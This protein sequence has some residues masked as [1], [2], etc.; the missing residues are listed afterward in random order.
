MPQSTD[1]LMQNE[2]FGYAGLDRVGKICGWNRAAELIT[3]YRPEEVIGK[4][5]CLFFTPEDTALKV[6][7]REMERALEMGKAEDQRW[8]LKKDGTRF[9]AAGAMTVSRDADGKV[10]GLSKIFR[11]DT[12]RKQTEDHIKS[13]NA[14]LNRFSYTVAHD[15]QQPLRTLTTYVELAFRKNLHSFD[16]ES[17]EY[18]RIAVDASKRMRALISDLLA[19]SKSDHK[20]ELRER[21]DCNAIFEDAQANLQEH[22]NTARA[23]IA[24]ST[25]PTLPGVG[26]QLVQVF[27]NLLENAIKYRRPDVKLEIRVD[28]IHLPPFWRFSVSD[29]GVGIADVDKER[30]F[31][32]FERA[33]SGKTESGS[34]LGLSICK[35]IVEQHGGTIWVESNA[36]HGSTFFFT[37]R[38]N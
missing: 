29:N 14:D 26:S 18:V 6:P 2:V 15:L 11:D 19:L 1:E 7:D 32:A 12:V 8:H 23:V 33:H 35:N 13:A 27:Q 24:H 36:G 9:W 3:G 28:A 37:L 16:H 21:V 38:E 17:K 22:L 5:V 31:G 30:I 4:N 25:F 20:A 34:G 10:V